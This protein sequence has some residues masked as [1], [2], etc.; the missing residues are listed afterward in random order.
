MPRYV[1]KHGNGVVKFSAL[2][3]HYYVSSDTHKVPSKVQDAITDLMHNSMDEPSETM[4]HIK[5]GVAIVEVSWEPEGKWGY[6]IDVGEPDMSEDWHSARKLRQW[7][8]ET[9]EYEVP[10]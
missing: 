1:D 6:S 2:G 7:D 9:H 4:E 5:E 8:D 10:A 3:P